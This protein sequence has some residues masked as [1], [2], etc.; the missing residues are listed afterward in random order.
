MS[1]LSRGEWSRLRRE[2]WCD[3]ADPW[4]TEFPARLCEAVYKND[5]DWDD[6]FATVGE[7]EAVNTY[8]QALELAHPTHE[9]ELS[10]V[11]EDPLIRLEVQTATALGIPYS[12]FL[13]WADSDQAYA[14]A[15]QV[16]EN[17]SCPSCGADSNEQDGVVE[18][19]YRIRHCQSCISQEAMSEHMKNLSDDLRRGARVVRK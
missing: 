6:F 16:Y 1:R 9:T 8:N 15:L 4:D 3:L 10:V 17:R 2:Y 12:Q 19:E 18:V 7:I 11:T 14:I 13:G 5:V